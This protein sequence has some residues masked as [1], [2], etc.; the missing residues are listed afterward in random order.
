MKELRGVAAL[1]QLGWVVAISILIPL[2]L[3]LW[4][5]HQ[6][7]TSPLFIL[8]GAVLGILV[9]T[10]GVVRIVVRNLQTI[11]KPSETDEGSKGEDR[12]APC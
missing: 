3:G 7:S 8:I 12:G 1:S 11:E 5:D 9:S 10:A 6:L 4:L 2:G